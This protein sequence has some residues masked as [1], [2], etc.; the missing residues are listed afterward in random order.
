[1][2]VRQI[3]LEMQWVAT[4]YWLPPRLITF[5]TC[6]HTHTHIYLSTLPFFFHHHLLS[7]FP[8]PAK[9]TQIFFWLILFL[10]RRKLKI[11]FDEK[12]RSDGKIFGLCRQQKIVISFFRSFG[13]CVS[14]VLHTL[15]PCTHTPRTHSLLG[16]YDIYWHRLTNDRRLFVR[17]IVRWII[18][19]FS[20]CL[21]R[22]KW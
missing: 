9:N 14:F 19:L 2:P 6:T 16:C 15:A 5:F 13:W 7:S 17:W 21:D 11:P 20:F 18:L 22:T 4:C 10:V 1:M 3:S 12:L 8:K